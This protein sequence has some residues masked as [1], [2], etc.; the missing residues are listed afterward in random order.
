M[1]WDKNI[2]NNPEKFGMALVATLEDPES[3]YDYDT[4][5]VLQDRA[6]ALHWTTDFG[7][8]CP[9]PFE[10]HG[11]DDL[12][13]I[14]DDT[15]A[16]FQDAVKNHALPYHEASGYGRGS[17]AFA[18]EKVELLAKVSAYMRAAKVGIA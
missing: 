2:Y 7:C 17:A 1:S 12:V 18:V 13:A 14:T 8:S 9:S 15:W 3:C 6:G 16:E 11:V 10:Y 4:L 5:I